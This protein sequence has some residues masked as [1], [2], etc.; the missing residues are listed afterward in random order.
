[1]AP[2]SVAL[3]ISVAIRAAGFLAAG[4]LVDPA[5]GLVLTCAHVLEGVRGPIVVEMPDGRRE[6]AR[7]VSRDGDLDAAL[8]AIAP[9]DR[10]PP[11]FAPAAALLAGSALAAVGSPRGRPFTAAAGSATGRTLR[12]LDAVLTEVRMPLEPGDSGGPVVD[13]R[14]RLRG[15]VGYV[16][17]GALGL[18]YLVRI[19][20]IRAHYPQMLPAS[21]PSGPPSAPVQG[22]GVPASWTPKT[23]AAVTQ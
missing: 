19:E 12:L 20:D 21:P 8:L 5:R 2:A 17:P 14:G 22:G 7:L 6:Q 15:I 13:A 9:S 18:G 10:A 16:R 23:S 4:V 1:M 11:A 3:S